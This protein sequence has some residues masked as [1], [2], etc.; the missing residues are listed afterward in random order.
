MSARFERTFTAEEANLLLAELRP[1]L[2]QARQARRQ[3][4]A[5]DPALEPTLARAGGN[6][7]GHLAGEAAALMERVRQ[8][9]QRIQAYGVLVKD[10][11]QG[12]LDFP[13]QRQGRIVLLCW[14]AGEPRVAHWHDLDSGFAGR[15]PL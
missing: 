5:I 7:G 10:L 9:V 8:A 3:L 6:G 11:E 1:L 13:S 14:K 4:I 12:L 15:Q 2:E